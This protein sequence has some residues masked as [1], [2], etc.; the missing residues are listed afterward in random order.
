VANVSAGVEAHV[1]YQIANA[2]IR[3]YPFPHL[4]VEDVFPYDFY[5]ELRRNW[6]TAASLVS[7]QSTGRVHPGYSAERFVMPLRKPEVDELPGDAR[8][9]WNDM[10]EWMIV[11]PRFMQSL[12]EK[13][14]ASVRERFGPRL[15]EVGFY[16]E[17]LVVRDRVNFT[18]GPHTD[19]PHRLM[20]LLFY[21]PD[22]DRYRHLGTSIYAPVEPGFRC[23]GARHHPRDRFK[24]VM[25]MEYK[26]NALFAFFKTD[27]SFH[28]VEPIG[29]D[30]VLRDLLLYDIRVDET[31]TAAT[32]QTVARPR[33]GFR[34]LR[35]IF[36]G[37]N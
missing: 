2:P 31:A 26:P 15:G 10:A 32:A 27:N 14:D 30:D 7:L 8:Q 24:R 36:G 4:Y 17:S 19:A 11:S 29:D 12:I 33:V 23:P 9:F 37:G 25:T 3:E 21:C 28:G 22:D 35:R 5:A 18:L 13:F 34:M 1:T 20:S 16:G 6:P